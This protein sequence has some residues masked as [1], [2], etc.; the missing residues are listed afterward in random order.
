VWDA[1]TGKEVLTLTGHRDAVAGVAFSPDGK[2][3]ASG[4]GYGD[5]TV[6]VWDVANGKEV[7]TCTGHTNTV[8]S[9][10][11]G[12]DGQRLESA[13]ADDTIRVWRLAD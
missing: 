4:S 5:G 9:V 7:L 3:L 2:R 6:R 11:F 8:N 13:S 10:A 1:V 12:K